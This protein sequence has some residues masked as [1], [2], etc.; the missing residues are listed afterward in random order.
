M[1]IRKFEYHIQNSLK[2]EQANV[3]TDKLFL[4]LE[5]KLPHKN[6]K[7]RPLIL[8][9]CA[10]LVLGAGY[11]FVQTTTP[12]SHQ[13][14]PLP[15]CIEHNGTPL[16]HDRPPVVD[17]AIARTNLSQV[18]TL[19]VDQNLSKEDH[20]TAQKIHAMTSSVLPRMRSNINTSIKAPN[21]FTQNQ[22]LNQSKGTT[23]LTIQPININ[24]SND[25]YKEYNAIT[26][27]LSTPYTDYLSS[28]VHRSFDPLLTTK[29]ECPSFSKKSKYLLEIR[30]EIGYFSPYK[31]LQ[32]ADN[33]E[34]NSVYM[35]RKMDEKPLEGIQAGLSLVLKKDN[36][37]FY[38]RGGLMYSRQSE[39]MNLSYSYEKLDTTQGI[40]SITKSQNGDTLTVIMGD[41]IERTTVE[42]S[43]KVHHYFKR[44]DVPLAL[45]YEI[46]NKNW[47]YGAEIGLQFNFSWIK[48]GNILVSDTSFAPI[49]QDH[50]FK[51]KLGATLFGDL[52][53]GYRLHPRWTTYLALRVRPQREIFTHNTALISQSYRPIGIHVGISYRI[54]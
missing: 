33:T 17:Q 10:I 50:S 20:D 25:E 3:D 30:P 15:E 27:L 7:K 22:N 48:E 41:I 1:D 44:W 47:I 9:L 21:K 52:H 39:R 26:S 19:N 42:G 37:P 13:T 12:K 38:L 53:L 32:L 54:F 46:R 43:S 35:L 16:D 40:I 5:P 24:H 8:V 51:S 4:E 28:S 18:P 49:A 29:I 11:Y 45:G 6:R 31:Q 14:R 36:T 23:Q 34:P 2:G